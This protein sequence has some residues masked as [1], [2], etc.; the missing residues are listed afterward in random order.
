MALK[1][2]NGIPIIDDSTPEHEYLGAKGPDG[3]MYCRGYEPR[4]YSKY[5]ATMFA[6]PSD[7]PLIDPGEY[8]AR[9]AEQE[10]QQSSLEHLYLS[11]PGGQPRFVNLDQ[12]G[13]G[14]CW[15]YSVGHTVML[16]RLRDNQPAVRMNPH[17]VAAIIKGGR[18]EGGWCGLSAEFYS[19]YG[20]APEGDG[21]GQWPLHSRNVSLDTPAMRESMAR[22]RIIEDWV[23]L[24]AQPFDRNLTQRQLATCLLSNMP[25]AVDFDWWGHS[26]CALRW[27]KV[28]S[29]SYG[30]LI[31][32]S[33]K[34]WGRFG[35]AVLQGEKAQ[36]MGAVC[37]RVIRATA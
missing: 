15:A 29:G 3:A 34:G 8:D 11:A 37:T 20:C 23:D 7:I 32:N 26:V 2:W 5:P 13:N 16:A 33:W 36:P 1:T 22:F 31:L 4:D 12:N 27:V 17:S 21:P 30:L 14:Y 35:L 25:C 24:T 9:I 28:E 19:K 10:A 18:D 6:P